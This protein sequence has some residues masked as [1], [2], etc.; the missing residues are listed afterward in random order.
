MGIRG[1][2]EEKK[3]RRENNRISGNLP[4]T[5]GNREGRGWG[6][7]NLEV[8]SSGLFWEGTSPP[9]P[10]LE[11]GTNCC[12]QGQWPLL[13]WHWQEPEIDWKEQVPS[14]SCSVPV[15]LQCPLQGEL[16]RGPGRQRRNVVCRAPPSSGFGRVDWRLRATSTR[17]SNRV[18]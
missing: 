9:P 5:W 14:A 4:Q 18:F 6:Y 7:Q 15:F 11:T 8:W 17:S 12:C 13:G 16:N 1:L 2:K 3:Q 10:N